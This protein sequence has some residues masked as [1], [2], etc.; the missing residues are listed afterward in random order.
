V[1]LAGVV[2]LFADRLAA[3]LRVPDTRGPGELIAQ[4]PLARPEWRRVETA[5]G[6]GDARAR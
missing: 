5:V 3:R 1:E 6:E 4:G 2:D